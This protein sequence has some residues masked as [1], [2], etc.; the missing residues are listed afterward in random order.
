MCVG[1]HS[2]QEIAKN[3]PWRFC[4]AVSASRN[5]TLRLWDL[6]RFLAIPRRVTIYP[7]L[8]FGYQT[9]KVLLPLLHR[10]NSGSLE[11]VRK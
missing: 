7:H 9:G 2:C 5:Q 11:P 6:V 3:R 1:A 4:L 8:T 10:H